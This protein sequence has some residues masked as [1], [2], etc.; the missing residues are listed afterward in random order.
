MDA[1]ADLH[2]RSAGRISP[3]RDRALMV[4]VGAFLLS[5]G[6]AYIAGVRFDASPLDYFLQ[7]L[8]VRLLEHDLLRSLWYLH[9]QP[10]LFNLLLGL[11]LKATH[12]EPG[13]VLAALWLL[14][15]LALTAMLYRLQR[16][17]GVR[18]ALAAGA[19]IIFT[20]GPPAILYENWLFYTYPE[21]LLLLAGAYFLH[22]YLSRE[23]VLDGALFS[24][25]LAC[26][27]LMRSLFHPAW[28]LAAAAIPV[29]ILPRRRR[30]L[31]L[32]APA[33]LLVLGWY[34]KN[35]ALFGSFSGSSWLGLS[36]A[37][38]T[39]FQLS[40]ADRRQMIGRGEIS[41]TALVTPYSDLRS[42]PYDSLLGSSPATG[43][44]A[45]D[46]VTRPS[47]A[48][49]Y[50]HHAVPAI[51]AA[52]MHDAV[53]V[54]LHHPATLLKGSATA[55]YYYLFPSSIYWF[56]DG[57]RTRIGGYDR[58]YNAIVLGQVLYHE[59]PGGAA[60]KRE[61]TARRVLKVSPVI[62]IGVPATIIAGMLLSIRLGRS[63]RLRSPLGG[64]L[65]YLVGTVLWVTVIG[66]ALEINENYRFRFTVDPLLITLATTTAAGMTSGRRRTEGSA[67][68]LGS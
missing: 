34:G 24:A 30:T 15:G 11:A 25:S 17:L 48:S 20:A 62:F 53:Y 23:R 66:N 27:V 9:S 33:V 40:E 6:A 8:D 4:V 55:Y 19:T 44:P 5:R 22:R 43:I 59:P 67:E 3:F 2:D 65:L 49:N 7:F 28:L 29:I 61:M 50:N 47:G 35:A 16:R 58:I 57:N 31:A 41:G 37:K 68:R 14:F 1:P 18:P 42:L 26:L 36:V 46:E 32:L 12:G 60:S 21:T 64:T 56:L 13:T 10:P 38:M 45:L 54:G 63:R 51:S 39:T 52:Y